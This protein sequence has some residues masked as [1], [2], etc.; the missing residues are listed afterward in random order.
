MKI[1]AVSWV[2]RERGQ[3]IPPDPVC[4]GDYYADKHGTDII[5]ATN[6]KIAKVAV[7][8]ARPCA[9]VKRPTVLCDA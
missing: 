1:F 9:K 8:M 6:A 7:E 2:A 3:Y 4:G 5:T